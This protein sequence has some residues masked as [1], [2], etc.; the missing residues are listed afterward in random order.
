TREI[1]DVCVNQGMG[2]GGENSVY[3]DLTHKDPDYLTRKL[4]GILEIYEKFVGDDPRHTPMKIFPA[5]HYSMG[6]LWT[7]FTPGSYTPAAPAPGHVSGTRA[8]IGSEIGMGLQPGA[9]ENA[10]TNIEGLYAFGEVSFAYHGANRLGAN[11]LLSCIFDGLFC[12]VGV[13]NYLRDG[14]PSKSPAGELD[15]AVFR[16]AA[17]QEERTL[18]RLLGTTGQPADE[19][20]NPYIIHK[21]LGVEMTAACTVVREEGRLRQ[22]LATIASLRDRYSR[23]RLGDLAA[24]TNQSLAFTRAVGDMLILAEALA[25]GAIERRESRG[26]HYRTDYPERD[27]AGFMKTSLA[28]YD[29]ASGR[30]VLEFIPIDAS[31]VVPRARTY[32]KKE[33]A[34]DPKKQAQ[35]V[36]AT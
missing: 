28:K 23:V 25:M 7:S 8:P 4:G 12:G 19:R 24:W 9:I 22:C 14:S 27:D 1:F 34:A 35:A 5:V 33:S 32:G 29:A 16:R 13:V 10:R 26:A 17:E 31:L 6:G 30:T 18:K 11:A 15:E 36:G 2:V 21:E 20:T 3:L